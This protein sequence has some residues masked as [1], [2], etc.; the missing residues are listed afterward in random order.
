MKG[1]FARDFDDARAIFLPAQKWINI[2]KEYYT[3]NEFCSDYIEI[4][5]DYAALFKHLAFFEPSLDR[6]IKMHKRRIHI[7]EELLAELNS[8]VYTDVFHAQLRDLAETYELV[9]KLK[10]SILE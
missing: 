3:I 5:T 7:L 2:A 4:V 9:Y 8:K 10:V 1:K 6:Q